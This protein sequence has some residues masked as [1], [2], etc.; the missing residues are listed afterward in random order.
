MGRDSGRFRT[1][2]VGRAGGRGCVAARE[3]LAACGLSAVVSAVFVGLFSITSPLFSGVS[4]DSDIFFIIGK[5][6]TEGAVPYRDLW[7]SKGPFLFLVNALGYAMTGSMAGVALVQT[8]SLTLTLYY[9]WR[10]LR[11]AFSFRGSL[12]AVAV[13]LAALFCVYDCG[14]TAEEYVMPFLACLFFRFYDRLGSPVLSV[15]LTDA[16]L[17]GAVFALCLCT[18]LTNAV[19]LC[20]ATLALCVLLAKGR[21]WA[22]LLRSAAAFVAGTAAVVAP[23]AVYFACHDTLSE[24]VYAVLTYNLEYR[25]SWSGFTARDVLVAASNGFCCLA[26]L[27]VAVLMALGGQRRRGFCWGAVSVALLLYLYN[28]RLFPHYFMVSVPCLAVAMAEAARLGRAV[29]PPPRLLAWV[30]ALALV[31]PVVHRSYVVWYLMD[32]S[33]HFE[34]PYAALLGKIPQNERDSFVAYNCTTNIYL[35]HGLKPACRFFYLQDWMVEQGPGLRPRLVAD[36]ERRG[37]KWILAQG[38]TGGMA[39]AGM[40]RR[41]YV[42]AG[43]DRGAGLTLFKLRSPSGCEPENAIGR[44]K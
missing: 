27:A 9:I 16:A 22:V 1:Q 26:L 3:R 11:C 32:Y 44:V 2:G 15:R 21:R 29:A 23:F 43:R 8:V 33:R 6:W 36:F 25:A 10:L 39:I 13:V 40:L 28:T 19:G 18:R 4:N 38:D 5:Y 34:D 30:L 31:P 24:A 17:C 12:L 35:L 42:V 7:D 37:V 20:A 14:N 41:R